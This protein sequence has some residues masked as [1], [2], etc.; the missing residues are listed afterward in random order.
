M[1]P[2]FTLAV[3]AAFAR[4][5]LPSAA[6]VMIALWCVPIWYDSAERERVWK[7]YQQYQRMGGRVHRHRS[8]APSPDDRDDE[9]K[10]ELS[11]NEC[12]I[13]LLDVDPSR[14]RDGQR[15]NCGHS[16]HRKCISKWLN[17]EN[18]CP[19]CQA[20]VSGPFLLLNFLGQGD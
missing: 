15:L 7:E 13:C 20:P 3:T 11:E 10:E 6:A 4:Q 1:V 18:R 2:A 17:R 12:A 5:H 14:P 16:F 9:K 8:G 19:L